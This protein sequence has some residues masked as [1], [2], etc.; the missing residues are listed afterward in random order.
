MSN[1][2]SSG[3]FFHL[4]LAKIG[5]VHIVKSIHHFDQYESITRRLLEMGL[6]PGTEV[7]IIHQAPMTHDPIVIQ[8]RG[9]LLACRR[10]EVKGV[11]LEC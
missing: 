8:V 3:E 9:T 7:E 1:P 2:T 5:N 6:V 11:E 4:G 10:A